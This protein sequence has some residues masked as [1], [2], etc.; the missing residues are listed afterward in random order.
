MN[1]GTPEYI[2]TFNARQSLIDSYYGPIAQGTD[3][4]SILNANTKS[5]PF[6]LLNV[7]IPKLL[8]LLNDMK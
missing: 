3:P 6:A 2:R 7:S 5:F 1:E 4:M 8:L